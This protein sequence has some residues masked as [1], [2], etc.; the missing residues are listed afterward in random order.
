MNKQ[1]IQE[2]LEAV[3]YLNGAMFYPYPTKNKTLAACIPSH[4]LEALNL[5]MCN[6][7][8]LQEK[9]GENFLEELASGEAVVMRW[10]EGI[11]LAY[12]ALNGARNGHGNFV[13]WT[14]KERTA[15]K[16]THYATFNGKAEIPTPKEGE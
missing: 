13:A 16:Q 14:T 6:I 7:K 9:C 8:Q 4:Y 1:E 2:A 5:L 15:K 3:E 10:E 12:G 11:T